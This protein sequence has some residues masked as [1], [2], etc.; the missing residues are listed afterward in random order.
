M[1]LWDYRHP[2]VAGRQYAVQD[3][4]GL[5]ICGTIAKRQNIS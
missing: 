5:Q 2:I 3:E 1:F 4:I